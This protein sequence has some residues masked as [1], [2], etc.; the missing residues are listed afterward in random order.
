MF[1]QKLGGCLD[2]AEGSPALDRAVL[3]FSPESSLSPHSAELEVRCGKVKA[4]GL[5]HSESVEKLVKTRRM[6]MTLG[7]SPWEDAQWC[8]SLRW[9][10]AREA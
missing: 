10:Q 6:K 4:H 5:S 9:G 1:R 8:L 3:C 2:V 7:P